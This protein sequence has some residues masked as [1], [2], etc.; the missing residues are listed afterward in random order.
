[1]ESREIYTPSRGF[2]V[3]V[4]FRASWACNLCDGGFPGSGLFV[5]LVWALS[6]VRVQY[7]WAV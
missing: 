5:R 4:V 6:R 2:F 1:M 3:W 7:L